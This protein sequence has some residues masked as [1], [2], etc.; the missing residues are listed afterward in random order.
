[1]E[2]L[3]FYILS[4][5]SIVLATG[6]VFA[7]DLVRGIISFAVFLVSIAG[8][9]ALMNIPFLAI[10]Q[11]VI[12]VGGLIFLLLFGVM[13][14]RHHDEGGDKSELASSGGWTAI[15]PQK[16]AVVSVLLILL[17]AASLISISGT[18]EL[19]DFKLFSVMLFRQYWDALLLGVFALFVALVSA[20][21]LLEEE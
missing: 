16:V 9:L 1:M 6:A 8:F 4:T 17:S 18:R 20:V 10:G 14:G 12:F 2:T 15:T 5:A 19:A 13:F 7:K 11:L 3:A 21:F